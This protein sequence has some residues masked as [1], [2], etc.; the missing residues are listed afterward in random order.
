MMTSYCWIFSFLMTS[1]SQMVTSAQ[2]YGCMCNRTWFVHCAC[3]RALIWW[4]NH[5][6][7]ISGSIT[8]GF[9]VFDVFLMT[10][11]T[12]MPTSAKNDVTPQFFLKIKNILLC[13]IILRSF[14]SKAFLVQKLDGRGKFTSA[15][16]G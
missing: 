12:K 3:I 6:Q 16:P 14:K 1:S 9:L 5:F 4:V 13:S 11:S 2:N 10:S 15:P 8:V 7:R